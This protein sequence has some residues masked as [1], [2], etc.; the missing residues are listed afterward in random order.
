MCSRCSGVDISE[1]KECLQDNVKVGCIGECG[2]HVGKSFGYIKG[3]F[4]I[5]NSNKEFID[6]AKQIYKI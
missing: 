3:E 2:Q 5:K 4:I 1:L 6:C